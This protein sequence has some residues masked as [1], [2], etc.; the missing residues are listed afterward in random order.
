MTYDIMKREKKME[1]IEFMELCDRNEK[2][3]VRNICQ[4]FHTVEISLEMNS[5]FTS[6]IT[7]I[8]PYSSPEIL[9]E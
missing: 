2:L 4:V 1:N 8:F 7:N 5:N 3:E 6:K 9:Y